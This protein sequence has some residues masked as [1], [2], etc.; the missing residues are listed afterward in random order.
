MSGTEHDAAGTAAR[1]PGAAGP[2]VGLTGLPI[3]IRDRRFLF[4][5]AGI[6]TALVLRRVIRN[7]RARA[8][9]IREPSARTHCESDV[10][11]RPRRGPH[12]ASDPAAEARAEDFA[13]ADRYDRY[14]G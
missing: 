2:A 3:R 8:N 9:V 12:R 10:G 5:L 14:A 4:L 11:V 7:S 1:A 13:L 6:T